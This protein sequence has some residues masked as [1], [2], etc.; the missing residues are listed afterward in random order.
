MLGFD[1][2]P[3]PVDG[4]NCV[5][6]MEEADN[7][8]WEDDIEEYLWFHSKSRWTFNHSFFC[9]RG[10][11]VMPYVYFNRKVGFVEI[12]WDNELWGSQGYIFDSLKGA[13][14]VP[15]IEFREC[16]H[17]F[18]CSIVADLSELNGSKDVIEK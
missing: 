12:A 2:F 18:I 15:Y 11:E 8:D 17:S 1:P 14:N 3:L 6:Q 9:I 10:S 13:A 16:L 7:F 4:S 5:E